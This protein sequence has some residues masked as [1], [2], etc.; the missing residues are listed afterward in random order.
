MPEVEANLKELVL[1]YPLQLDY[2]LKG[3]VNTLLQIQYVLVGLHCVGCFFYQVD[4]V[5]Y[6]SSNGESYLSAKVLKA[7]LGFS[8]ANLFEFVSKTSVL[9]DFGNFLDEE[10]EIH[11]DLFLNASLLLGT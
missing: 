1:R 6:H 10:A 7:G 5:L 4:V 8:S 9:G 11:A 2:E 3:L